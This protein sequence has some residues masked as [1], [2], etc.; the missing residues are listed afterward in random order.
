VVSPHRNRARAFR[1]V[2]TDA[3]AFF[4]SLVRD[5]R[6]LGLKFRRQHV[7]NRYILDFYCHEIR[8]GIELDGVG[9]L[10]KRQTAHDEERMQTLRGEGIRILRFWNNDVLTRTDS[11][12]E[13]LYNEIKALTPAPLPEGEG[14]RRPGEG[15]RSGEAA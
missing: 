9:H 3:E 14:G 7:V 6:F 10:G 12:L 11:V 15:E 8:L 13:S 2:K 1:K 5:R 4:W